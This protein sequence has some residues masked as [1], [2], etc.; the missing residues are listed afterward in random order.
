VRA[1]DA[2]LFPAAMSSIGLSCYL[3]GDCTPPILTFGDKRDLRY[4]DAPTHIEVGMPKEWSSL[5]IMRPFVFAPNVPDD[6][7]GVIRDALVKA[8]KDS[9]SLEWGKKADVP[10]DFVDSA[11]YKKKFDD[12]LEIYK[13]YPEHVKKYLF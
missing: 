6:K 2:D 12:L 7:I 5:R 9:R 8:L 13:R 3:D 10:M 4:P 1:G 11:I